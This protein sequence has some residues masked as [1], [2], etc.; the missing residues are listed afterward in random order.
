MNEGCFGVLKMFHPHILS[1]CFVPLA[2]CNDI[3]ALWLFL[4]KATF[5][6]L[7]FFLYLHDKKLEKGVKF[8]VEN[9]NREKR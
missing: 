7:I 2:F 6:T 3:R 9:F 8:S 1:I 4:V 5:R